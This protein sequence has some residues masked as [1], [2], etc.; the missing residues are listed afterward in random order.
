MFN[1]KERILNKQNEKY[2]NMI[3]RLEELMAYAN[4]RIEY[5]VS[6]NTYLFDQ[7]LVFKIKHRRLFSK[8]KKA[9][10]K[11]PDEELSYMIIEFEIG[12]IKY[13]LKRF[14]LAELE[15]T[16]SFRI[17]NHPNGYKYLEI[18]NETFSFFN[19]VSV[20]LLN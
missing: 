2:T 7:Q 8:L 4:E 5:S 11:F 6:K 18:Q 3:I 13:R 1:L 12:E 9:L 14:K 20:S 15:K 16:Y 10:L 17:S 19:K